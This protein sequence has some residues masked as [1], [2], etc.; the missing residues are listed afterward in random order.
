VESLFV[1]RE[2]GYSYHRGAK[3][4]K[5]ISFE[6]E[7]GSCSVILGANG[8]G[9]STLLKI[10]DMLILPQEGEFFA[11]DRKIDKKA[12]RD[13]SFNAF[14]RKQVGFVF[15][16]PDTQLFLPTVQDELM[17]APLQMGYSKEDAKR[18]AK[19]AAE[20]IGIEGL[21]DSFPFDLSEGEKKKV[22][23]ASICTLDPEVWILDEPIF[24][25]DPKTQWWMVS[26][27]KKLKE[28]GKTLIIA[29]HSIKLAEL[30]ADRCVVLSPN[31]TTAAVSDL[32]IL[33][34]SE[35]LIEN[36]LIHPMGVL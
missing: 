24:S 29:T 23:I 9:K 6:I 8:S 36:N 12:Q 7:K 22:A 13:E 1:L 33:Q 31:H 17:F 28:E 4:L 34:D 27:L 26:F 21:L 2:V 19:K 14:F 5:G 30:L 3:A 10:L 15:Q 18:L 35:L 20:E 16:N 25:L 11:F 32:S